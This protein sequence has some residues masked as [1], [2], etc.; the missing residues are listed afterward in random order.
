MPLFTYKAI[1]AQGKSV[2]GRI[3]AVNLFD[4]EQRLVRMDLDLVAGA[5]A[6]DMSRLL[7]GGRVTRQDL[8]NFCFH[9]EQLATAGVPL[10]EGLTDLRD[11]IE[12]PRFREIVSGLIESIQGGHNLSQALADYPSV[13]SKVFISLVR[14]GE[15][16]GKLAEVLKSLTES[17]KWED[18]LAAQ[19]KK[20][21]M[22]PAFVGSIVLIVTFFLMIYLVPQMTGFIR[23][24]GQDIP[25]QTRILMA[26]SNFFVNYWWAII[27]LPFVAWAGLKL[28]INANPAV[29]Y[30]VDRYKI[31]MPLVGPILRKI[32]LSRFASS[33]AMM[34]SSGIT[35]L[36]SIRSCEE[37]VGN[38]PLEHALRKAGQQ[39][40]EGKNLTAAFQDLALFPPLVIR[41]MRIGEN[42]GKLDTALL[43][44]SYFYNREVREEIGKVQ[45]LIEPALT[46]VLGA[47][48]GWV[49]LSVLG[50][51][52]DAISKMKF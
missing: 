22:Y 5:P 26:V 17:L 7:G 47:I 36:D 48:L 15:Q 11:S 2:V 24:M 21:A 39:I 42:T 45:A 51:V 34:Y 32:I 30:A 10:M 19:T 6:S 40:A 25:L 35:V 8:I 13:F 27:A 38:R 3:E 41:M 33:F 49:M 12:N 14:S 9:L 37:I 1:D 46:V 50:P 52:Y 43:N 29:E 20:L 18:E 4:L 23:N 28:A 44:I 16:T 31:S